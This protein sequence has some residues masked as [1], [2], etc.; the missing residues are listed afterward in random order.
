ML[1]MAL[2][3]P[4]A[5]AQPSRKRPTALEEVAGG[6]A[7]LFRAAAGNR[8]RAR[9]VAQAQVAEVAMVEPIQELDEDQ[10]EKQRVRV[11]AYNE[12]MLN[13]LTVTCDL[14]AEQQEQVRKIAAA[15]AETL[16]QKW[17]K[18][19]PRN[20][21]GQLSP[22][23][24][25]KFTLR[26]GGAE[27]LDLTRHSKELLEVLSED[28]ADRLNEAKADRD[29]FF[30]EAVTGRVLNLLDAELYLSGQQR[31]DMRTQLQKRL[32]GMES[33]SFSLHGQ[34]YYLPQQSISFLLQRGNHL[35]VLSERQMRRAKD[36]AQ[37][38]QSQ[39]YNN[40]Q[41]IQFESSAGVDGWHEHLEKSAKEQK[42]RV[43]R[44]CSVRAD[45]YRAEWQ[46]PEKHGRMMEIVAKGVADRMIADWK[47]TVRRQL[48]TYEQQAGA[49]GGN[50]SFSMSVVDLDKIDK[51]PLWKHTL[52]RVRPETPASDY[53]RSNEMR[54]AT[55]RHL[56]GLLDRELWLLP[57][58]R[59]DV[60]QLVFKTIPEDGNLRSNYTYM[61]DVAGLVIPMFKF[62]QRDAEIF[63]D[64]QDFIWDLMK[65]NFDFN[66]SY[67]IVALPNGGQFHFN[68]PN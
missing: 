31:N 47:E 40:E 67:V 43:L 29:A 59:P 52:D 1:L 28:Q 12:A 39:H 23:F 22:I 2:F 24:P 64:D 18:V 37:I 65:E 41:Y 32:K 6:L 53:D 45:F 61:E 19:A 21:N 16:L 56:T 50:F 26:Y 62:S 27:S 36:L 55:A 7:E 3:A 10:K 49:F 46:L 34:S 13:W 44:G 8:V 5:N 30:L 63:D 15:K 25:V 42:A 35:D 9:P 4:A 60:E 66:G 14:S 68:I 58:Q 51:E 17:S 20:Q 48:K 38:A 57:A 54:Q 33:T 11:G